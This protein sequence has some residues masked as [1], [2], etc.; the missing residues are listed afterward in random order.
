MNV[1]SYSAK[2]RVYVFIKSSSTPEE[3][4]PK[5]I[6]EKLGTLTKFKSYE[7]EKDE[8]A[9]RVGMDVKKVY[10]GIESTGYYLGKLV[11]DVKET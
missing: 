7:I 2:G 3:S 6:L 4:I 9:P 8:K 10:S 11:V 1:T 5:D